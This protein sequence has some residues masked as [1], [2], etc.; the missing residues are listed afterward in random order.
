VL[1]RSQSAV[2]VLTLSQKSLIRELD[3]ISQTDDYENITATD[4]TIGREGAGLKTEYKLLPVPRKKASE[5]VIADAWAEA[6]S[7]G[8]D[9][10]RLMAGGN[11]FKPES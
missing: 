9:L 5:A 2:Q 7:A 1:F 4:F 6:Q 10:S 8:F 3:A 11:P